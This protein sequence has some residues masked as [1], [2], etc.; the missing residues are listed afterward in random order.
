MHMSLFLLLSAPGV[1]TFYGTLPGVLCRRGN[2]AAGRAVLQKLRGTDEVDAEY[3]DICDA[4][5]NAAKVSNLQVWLPSPS[6]PRI[7]RCAVCI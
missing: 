1:V 7:A 4:A 5:Q 6:M 3:A 2:W